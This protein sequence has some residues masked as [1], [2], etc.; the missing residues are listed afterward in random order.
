M[1]SW[2][3]ESPAIIHDQVLPVDRPGPFSQQ[4][5]DGGSDIAA[6]K[7]AEVADEAVAESFV[8]FPKHTARC[9]RGLPHAEGRLHH[10]GLAAWVVVF[11]MGSGPGQRGHAEYGDANDSGAQGGMRS[12]SLR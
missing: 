5:N 11:S 3:S 10:K 12:G 4:K 1:G 9:R 8:Q 2:C 6:L 7:H